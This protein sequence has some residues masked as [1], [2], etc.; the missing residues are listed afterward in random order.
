MKVY[1]MSV[2]R[3][4]SWRYPRNSASGSGPPV[5]PELVCE[6]T[7]RTRNPLVT[8]C[9]HLLCPSNQ[10]GSQ[11]SPCASVALCLW[12]PQFWI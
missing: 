1:L 2:I 12:Y 5:T 10:H 3:S 6:L 4:G 9:C 8:S 11:H 7:I